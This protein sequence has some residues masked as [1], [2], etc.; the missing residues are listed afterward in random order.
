MHVCLYNN[1]FMSTETNN[2]P[3]YNEL[4]SGIDF[5]PMLTFNDEFDKQIDNLIDRLRKQGY[6]NES[7]IKVTTEAMRRIYEAECKLL[8]DIRGESNT[9]N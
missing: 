1:M 2:D 6:D 8:E 3:D 5:S 4:L 9:I 7:I